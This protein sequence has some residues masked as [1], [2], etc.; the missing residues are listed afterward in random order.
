MTGA[1]RWSVGTQD[2]ED[3]R[4]NKS[5][6]KWKNLLVKNTDRYGGHGAPLM[7]GVTGETK[8][9]LRESFSSLK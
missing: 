4:S 5:H 2:Q 6:R 7:R 1:G 3:L 8:S 9:Q